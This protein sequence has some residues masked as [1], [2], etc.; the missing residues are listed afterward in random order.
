MRIR[1]IFLAAAAAITMLR[2]YGDDSAKHP[3]FPYSA[4]GQKA[5][6]GGGTASEKILKSFTER[7]FLELVPRQ[8]PRSAQ[9]CPTEKPPLTHETR[10]E[11]DPHRPNEIRWG[12]FVFPSPNYVCKT[13]RVEVLSGK[14]VEVPYLDTPY[15]RS[16][17]PAQ[18]DHCKREELV[19]CLETL[20]KDYSA[21][22]D[23]RYARRIAVALDAW[24][25]CFP[26]YFMTSE[27][28]P[29]LVSPAQAEKIKWDVRRA[30]D[31]GRLGHEWTNVELRAFDAI[32]N[33][34]ALRDLSAERGYDVRGHIIK[35]HFENEA[36]FLTKRVPLE[37]ATSSGLSTLDVVANAATLLGRPDYIG[38]VNRFLELAIANNFAR[39]GMYP[40][41]F[42]YHVMYP[43]VLFDIVQAVRNYFKV[44]PNGTPALRDAKAQV[45]DCMRALRRSST[46]H[47]NVALPNG[48]MAPFD[49]TCFGGAPVRN[50]TRSALL[51]AYGHVMLGD[52]DGPRQA[53]ANLHFADHYTHVHANS[54]ALA[55]Y[56]F[57]EELLDNNRYFH[58]FGFGYV[59]ST[60]AYNTVTIDRKQQFR[61]NRDFRGVGH[62]QTGGD[63]KTYEPGLA[64][65]ALAHV[66]GQ[67]A[68]LN[69]PDR[70]YERMVV[71]NTVDANHPYLLDVFRVGGGQ[72]HDY[73]LHGAITFPEVAQAS[74][75]LQPI[76]KT[77]PLLEAGETWSESDSTKGMYGNAKWYGVFRE[78]SSGRSPGNWNVT[79]RNS[80]GTLGTCIH[81]ADSGDSQVYLG[82]S[83]VG[84]RYR[85]AT[86][87]ST[88]FNEWRPTLLVR[89]QAPAGEALQSLFVSVIEPINGKPSI[90]KVERLPLEQPDPA[91]VA[92]GI[93][94]ADGRKD[95]CIAN[96]SDRKQTVATADKSYS[97]RGRF[98]L[99]SKA[100]GK[101]GNWL[102]AGTELRAGDKV[103]AVPD[104]IREGTVTAVMR[105]HDGAAWDAFVTDA[106]LPEGPALK[107][108]WLSL[109]F[110]PCK[111]IPGL[112]GSYPLDIKEQP[113]I[114]QMFQIDHVERREGKTWI[115]ITEDP[116]LS[117]KGGFAAETV[118]PF[119]TFNGPH[120][121]EIA[122][123]RYAP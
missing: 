90:T 56:A 103:V 42:S 13:E 48:N 40:L 76:A 38:Y 85:G 94:F 65:V 23:E 91:T 21:T 59:N 89:R 107:G 82:K 96:L 37:T 68:Y 66:D 93:T 120:H 43:Q 26:D 46:V 35:N 119:R 71:L 9:R 77:Y 18:I 24:A 118:W 108:R 34:K 123:S 63:L 74:F 100:K 106:P 28:S 98:G 95:V 55:L 117:L 5:Q 45:D 64:G 49:D 110:G 14:T 67:R 115:C 80:A 16:Y 99:V 8:S 83:P 50:A 32:W 30:S 61:G 12:S 41:S 1:L 112:D 58:G 113:G 122:Q 7:E 102:I 11:W 97:L 69:I 6:E 51:P 121:F 4:S 81:V 57:G 2:V 22:H 92:L 54:L 78:M 116:A 39:D 44:H 33:S 114:S 53:Q 36:D 84:Y 10:W 52:G 27:N 19:K 47:L 101:T 111:L 75:P 105:R 15:G 25:T 86:E 31:H 20:A 17:V 70:R 73:F 3:M 104:G 88:V 62:L 109:A 72:T 87:P 29:N 60:M 79:F